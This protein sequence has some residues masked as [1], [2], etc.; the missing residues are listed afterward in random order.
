MEQDEADIVEE[1][2]LLSLLP[3]V[4]FFHSL[5]TQLRRFFWKARDNVM[6][7]EGRSIQGQRGRYALDVC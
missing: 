1:I 2:S 7:A 4:G 6:H 5:V 3:P